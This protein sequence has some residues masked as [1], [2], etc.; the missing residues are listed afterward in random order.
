[1]DGATPDPRANAGS[2]HNAANAYLMRVFFDYVLPEFG[3]D[4]SV[5]WLRNPDSTEHQFGPGPA[6]YQDA[7]RDQDALL[8][9]L[10]SKLEALN[11]S[12]STDLIVISD[13]GHST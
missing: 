8:G 13:H 10:Q 4:L 12:E 9:K 2:A 1:A 7:L 3:P 11:L 6:N 5:V